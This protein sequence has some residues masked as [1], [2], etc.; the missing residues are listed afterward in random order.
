MSVA[1][2]TLNELI[3]KKLLALHT[4][5]LAIVLSVEGDKFG[6]RKATIQ[7]LAMIKAKGKD[8]KK[9]APMTVPVLKNVHKFR[10]HSY[11]V[12]D[13]TINVTEAVELEKNDVVMCLCCERDISETQKGNYATPNLGHHRITDAVIVG[14]I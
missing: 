12:G 3:D 6:K 5:F 1:G 2:K 14:V 13:T 9:Q 8:A 7:P 4:A 10:Q 11:I